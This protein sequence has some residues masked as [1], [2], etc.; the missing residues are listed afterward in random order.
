[1]Q[2]V[3]LAR[4]PSISVNVCRLLGKIGIGR[5]YDVLM[6]HAKRRSH[7]AVIPSTK[8]NRTATD[9]MVRCLARKVMAMAELRATHSMLELLDNL[10]HTLQFTLLR[11]Y[12][13]H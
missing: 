11:P 10:H 2:T 12:C 6:N 9:V 13:I 1:C 3:L 5:A 8:A 7:L 4:N